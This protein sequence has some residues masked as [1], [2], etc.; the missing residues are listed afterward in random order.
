MPP[1]KTRIRLIATH[2]DH[3]DQEITPIAIADKIKSKQRLIGL[4][5]FQK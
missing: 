5:D 3:R 4:L 1:T 2:L